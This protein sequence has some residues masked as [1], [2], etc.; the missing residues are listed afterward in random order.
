MKLSEAIR[1]GAMLGP[2][3]FGSLRTS[4]GA[5]C[6][7]GAAIEANG[8]RGVQTWWNLMSPGCP[9]GC[10]AS[11]QVFSTMILLS[12]TIVHLNDDHHWTRECIADWVETVEDQPTAEIQTPGMTVTV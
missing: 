9:V 8:H 7:I 4:D 6:A 5:T 11:D 3:A 10:D 2:Q 1:L 12:A